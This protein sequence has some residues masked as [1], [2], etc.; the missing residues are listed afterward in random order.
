MRDGCFFVVRLLAC[1][2]MCVWERERECRLPRQQ[3]VERRRVIR[4]HKKTWTVNDLRGNVDPFYTNTEQYSKR[5]NTRKRSVLCI[6]LWTVAPV[7]PNRGSKSFIH[8][9]CSFILAQPRFT[10]SF[11]VFNIIHWRGACKKIEGEKQNKK[12]NIERTNWYRWC[13]RD[14]GGHG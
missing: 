3:R 5:S 1:A 14:G 4:E 13:A 6:V 9:L 12:Y 10:Y 11:F 7:A 2:W 8:I